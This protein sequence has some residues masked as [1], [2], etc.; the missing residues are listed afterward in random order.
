M[1]F[2]AL[3]LYLPLSRP[4]A[5]MEETLAAG[6]LDATTQQIL[7][8]V[9]SLLLALAVGSLTDLALCLALGPGWAASL[10]FIAGLSGLI[11]TLVDR[12]GP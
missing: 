9:S 5:R 1:A 7:L 6:G 2:W 8:V 11:L 12:E 3:A 10:G 4:L